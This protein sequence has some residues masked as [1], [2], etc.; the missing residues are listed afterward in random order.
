MM[1]GRQR[2]QQAI[3][4][5]G[6]ENETTTYVH[7][8]PPP[9]RNSVAW[10]SVGPA[11]RVHRPSFK[12]VSGG[13]SRIHYGI[14]L[15]LETSN[16]AARMAAVK[17]PLLHLSPEIWV[18]VLEALLDV[19]AG[20][21]TPPT[22]FAR[23]SCACKKAHELVERYGWERYLRRYGLKRTL[24]RVPDPSPEPRAQAAESYRC[25][26]AWSQMQMRVQ[27]SLLAGTPRDKKYKALDPVL[28]LGTEGLLLFTKSSVRLCS[29]RQMGSPQ[30]FDLRR[31][32]QFDLVADGGA[33]GALQNISCAC[34]VGARGDKVMVGRIDGSLQEFHLPLDMMGQGD[35]IHPAPI[36]TPAIAS[37][38]AAPAVPAE[39]PLHRKIP[40]HPQ[41]D[42]SYAG[43]VLASISRTGR[44]SLWSRRD[45]GGWTQ[46]WE[47]DLHIQS[48]ACLLDQN[49]KWLAV[50]TTGKESL[51]IFP[52]ARDLS[53]LVP[54]VLSTLHA[55][56]G[57]PPGRGVAYHASVGESRLS[58]VFALVQHGDRLVAGFYDGVVRVYDLRQAPWADCFRAPRMPAEHWALPLHPVSGSWEE[59][60]HRHT[61]VLALTPAMHF[62][63]RFD[64]SAV[65][66][67]SLGTGSILAG[68]ATSGVVRMYRLDD[69]IS[70]E[71]SGD[72]AA[73]PAAAVAVAAEQEGFGSSLIRRSAVDGTIISLSS[74]LPP[75]S[76]HGWSIYA[77]YP[78]RS[79]VF[80]LIADCDR[81]VGVTDTLVFD[82]R[83]TH[84]KEQKER[85]ER[86]EQ[87]EQKE[88]KEQKQQKERLDAK[89]K[90][91]KSVHTLDTSPPFPPQK[92]LPERPRSPDYLHHRSTMGSSK[93]QLSRR[94]RER[95]DLT[96]LP[97]LPIESVEIAYA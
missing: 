24:A 66:S 63:D 67:L 52:L 5:G 43:N 80:A 79:P 74:S 64:D 2:R 42:V 48:W 58:S 30:G 36:S 96:V 12:N 86:K 13:H 78:S 83:V 51:R 91:S 27:R 97:Y 46:L 40:R 35:K 38:V 45:G 33:T 6:K 16:A 62:R 53:P 14:L 31:T 55:P 54:I 34:L 8:I 49:H 9:M 81:V 92:P 73:V 7:P 75:G 89:D 29:A 26:V 68:M 32:V 41:Q 84:P 88:E 22:S 87:K 93:A 23:L 21:D 72:L 18:Q 61:D 77:G 69:D 15:S 37:L 76:S 20:R 17:S 59:P 11:G 19:D 60:E 82:V 90:A 71:P 1:G 94:E 57:V 85:K 44:M 39:R 70:G 65:Y 10:D 95:E 25:R 28:L 50:G 4:F 3:F 56:P 47:A